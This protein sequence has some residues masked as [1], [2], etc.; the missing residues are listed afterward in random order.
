MR[1]VCAIR[2]AMEGDFV[3]DSGRGNKLGSRL[4]RGSCGE[5]PPNPPSMLTY[6]LPSLHSGPHETLFPLKAIPN[7]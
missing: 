6:P 1:T 3:R 5:M 7:G 4:W 2:F